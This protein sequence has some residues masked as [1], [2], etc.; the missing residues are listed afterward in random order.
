[1]SKVVV[2]FGCAIQMAY[3]LRLDHCTELSGLNEFVSGEVVKWPQSRI[4]LCACITQHQSP[5]NRGLLR[6]TS[7]IRLVCSSKNS[8]CSIAE[9][10]DMLMI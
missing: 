1:M 8:E 9:G 4:T 6:V 2:T 10:R 7:T 5:T 3:S